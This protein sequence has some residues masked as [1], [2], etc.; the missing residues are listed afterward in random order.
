MSN[1]TSQYYIVSITDKCG[2]IRLYVVVAY[3]ETHAV[4]TVKAWAEYG[5][6]NI[7]RVRLLDGDGLGVAMEFGPFSHELAA[8][9][10]VPDPRD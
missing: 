3:T 8:R 6:T 4:E 2:R 9:G 10:Y 7:L 5:I 1:P